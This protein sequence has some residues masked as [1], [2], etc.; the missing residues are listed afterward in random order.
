[1]IPVA[2]RLSLGYTLETL[3]SAL[4]VLAKVTPVLWRHKANADGHHPLWLRFTD[5]RR[6]LYA[7]LSVSLHPRHWND[8]KREVRKGHPHADR[9]NALLARRLADAEDERLRLLADREP[10]TA[11]ALK[12][13][14]VYT[15]AAPEAPCFLENARAFLAGVERRGNVSRFRKESAVLNKLA[16]FGAD[17]AGRLPYDTLTLAFLRDYEAHLIEEKKNKAST[18]QS[19]L[20]IIRAHYRRMVRDGVVPRESDPFVA[21]SPPKAARAERHKLTEAELSR[22]ERLDLGGTGEGAPLI[23]RVRDAFLFA[24][25]AAGVR[26]ADVAGLRVQDL[27]VETEA[28]PEAEP[29]ERLRLSYRM[30][31]TGKRAS[32]RL[33][34]SAER[35][36]RAYLMTASG[37]VKAPGDFLFPML[38]GPGYDLSTPRGRL[39]AV[40][41]QNTLHNKYLKAIAER[42]EVSGRL[43]FHVARHSFADLARRQGWDVYSISK[44]LAHSG[45]AVTERYLAGF[46][47]ELVDAKMD[48]L[49]D[50]GG[51]E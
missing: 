7:S 36:A 21:Y 1:M 51:A 4:T 47:R 17:R 42:A 31:K 20:N 26:F 2:L 13:A 44:A 40:A 33:I 12:A 46:D 35:I 19:N 45:L 15:E 38:A 5:T 49:F 50:R 8:R 22:I 27:T 6:T 18:A 32:L 10:V 39:N 16:A 11:E 37:E 43:T 29:V 34:P 41:S 48:G 28:G 24:L 23:A 14:V 30:S 3:T 25:Y 9:I